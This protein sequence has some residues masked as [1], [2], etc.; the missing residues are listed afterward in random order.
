MVMSEQALKLGETT[1][2]HVAGCL[3]VRWQ[4]IPSTLDYIGPGTHEARFA[5]EARRSEISDW[6]LTS[7]SSAPRVSSSAERVQETFIPRLLPL[8]KHHH[9]LTFE[10][11]R[12][13]E[14]F[15]TIVLSKALQQGFPIPQSGKVDVEEDPEEGAGQVVIRV[16]TSASPVQTFAFWD[17]LSTDIS[18]WVRTLTPKERETVLKDIAL[19][20]HWQS[21]V[22]SI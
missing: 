6:A 20:F 2:G 8:S 11:A 19:R 13:V 5:P 10:V 18:R 21:H 17:S 22:R 4:P 3:P 15:W 9:R 16:Y 12:L 14:P 1:L 7:E